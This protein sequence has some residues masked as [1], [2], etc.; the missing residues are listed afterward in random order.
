MLLG[1]LATKENRLKGLVE[2][3]GPP[4]TNFNK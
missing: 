3:L 4:I 2:D 1:K